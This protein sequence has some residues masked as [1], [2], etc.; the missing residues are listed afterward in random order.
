[1]SAAEEVTPEDWTEEVAAVQ[2]AAAVVCCAVGVF[3]L[4]EES[5]LIVFWKKSKME[6]E[7]LCTS[8]DLFL[9]ALLVE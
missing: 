1:M 7:S 2:A 4:T 5:S 9:D 6:A 8:H 3:I